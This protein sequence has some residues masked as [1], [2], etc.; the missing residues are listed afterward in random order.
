MWEDGKEGFRVVFEAR[1]GWKGKRVVAGLLWEGNRFARDAPSNDQEAL[2]E[3]RAAGL[4]DS[5]RGN[6][7]NHEQRGG[8]EEGGKVWGEKNVKG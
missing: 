8:R 5:G 7:E 1:A 3:P 2:S 6:N 4:D